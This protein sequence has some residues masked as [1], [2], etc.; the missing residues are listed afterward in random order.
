MAAARRD[1]ADLVRAC[2]DPRTG[3][4]RTPS[5]KALMT[6]LRTFPEMRVAS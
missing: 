1:L 4:R 2:I 6:A 3:H 5:K